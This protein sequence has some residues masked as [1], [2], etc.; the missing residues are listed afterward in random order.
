[1]LESGQKKDFHFERPL[2]V[3]SHDWLDGGDNHVFECIEDT[4]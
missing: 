4:S 2:Q 1:M 3:V